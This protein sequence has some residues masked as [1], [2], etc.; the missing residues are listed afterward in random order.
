MSDCDSS[1]FAT[2]CPCCNGG[3]CSECSGTGQ[4]VTTFIERPDGTSLRVSGNAQ[5][6]EEAMAA[7]SAVAD[8]AVK[9][10]TQEPVE[11]PSTPIEA[12]GP[13]TIRICRQCGSHHGRQH[14]GCVTYS[15]P[16]FPQATEHAG[17]DEVQVVPAAQLQAA[18]ERAD[19]AEE[20]EQGMARLWRELRCAGCDG[21]G[22][23]MSDA[24]PYDC[25]HCEGTGIAN[26]WVRRAE[27]A[28]VQRDQALASASED[29]THIERLETIVAAKVA[30]RD[31]LASQLQE[32]RR[33]RTALRY[34]ADPDNWAGDPLAYGAPL[35]GHFTP[36]ELAVRALGGTE[37]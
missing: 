5:L 26:G 36:Y 34:L 32:A 21:D 14:D 17:V 1:E 24:G 7:L 3:G 20:R 16:M 9:Q 22:E 19:R 31:Q 2:V 10:M 35:L 29:A 30:E 25:R 28:E 8:A 27:H 37:G 18:L 23:M 13:W 6:S 4:R 11:S 15:H 12:T 33:G